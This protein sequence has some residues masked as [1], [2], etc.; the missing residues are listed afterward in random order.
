MTHPT[1][2]YSPI[3]G[4]Q[5]R[6]VLSKKSAQR[7]ESVTIRANTGKYTSKYIKTLSNTVAH[8]KLELVRAHA[9][10]Y[11]VAVAPCAKKRT[12]RWRS[13]VFDGDLVPNRYIKTLSADQPPANQPATIHFISSAVLDSVQIVKMYRSDGSC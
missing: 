11:R 4:G 8:P 9:S 1:R 2:R 10:Y 13:S 3:T 6:G 5:L 12:Y 7:L